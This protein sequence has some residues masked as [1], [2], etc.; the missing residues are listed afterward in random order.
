MLFAFGTTAVKICSVNL[1]AVISTV[2]VTSDNDAMVAAVLLVRAKADPETRILSIY[3]PM[4]PAV[5]LPLLV[6]PGYC[7]AGRRA[8]AMVPLTVDVDKSILVVP[9][10]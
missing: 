8:A 6:S 5:A 4:F 1:P 7:P 3:S 9:R 10:P 2:L